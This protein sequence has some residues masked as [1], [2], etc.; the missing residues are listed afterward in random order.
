[1]AESSTLDVVRYDGS[2]ERISWSS[3]QMGSSTQNAP[4]QLHGNFDEGEE[5]WFSK[6]VYADG[7]VLVEAYRPPSFQEG[8]ELDSG[9]KSFLLYHDNN[10]A[11][12]AG[13][14]LS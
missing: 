4:F 6:L 10:T 9:R 5:V 2:G 13:W 11:T 3:V 14:R 1:M 7:V 8:N 12:A